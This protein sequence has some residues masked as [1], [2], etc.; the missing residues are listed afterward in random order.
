MFEIIIDYMM[1]YMKKTVWMVVAMAA[2]VLMGSCGHQAGR[3]S[4][5]R[6]VYHWKTTYNPSEWEKDWM[7]QHKVD[8]LYV[9]LFDVEAGD[10]VGDPD[11]RMVPTATT[12]F[13]QP[14]PD[15]IEVVPV[16][17]ITLD[18]IRALDVDEW[19]YGDK[20]LY[21]KLI[22]KRIK[23]MMAE[24]Y[25]GQVH[26]VQLDCDWTQ[27]TERLYFALVRE[28]KKL[29]HEDDILLS[30]TLRLHQLHEVEHPLK[31]DW[32]S[33]DSL[34]F[35][36][37]LLMCYNTG[38]L[39]DHATRN[40]ILDFGDVKPY[41]KQYGLD[42]LPRTDVALPTYGWGVEFTRD[43]QFIRIV[44]SHQLPEAQRSRWDRRVKI[45]EEW[46]ETQEIN[47]TKQALSAL[48]DSHTT[49]LYHLDSLNLSKYSYEDIEAFYRR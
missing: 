42:S 6:G 4:K 24:H 16:V 1:N 44:H 2:L 22:V 36:R 27:Q 23:V 20:Q 32:G 31:N 13:Q 26:E 43:N 37:S 17:Y 5:H 41:L 45:R 15:N 49:I 30:G 9:R 19:F 34:P 14:L 33:V 3:S 7:K 12:V 28:V 48:D 47:K 8:R 11:W 25:K 29:L 38:R 10:Q 46:G 39:Q 18:A 21:A 40:S 35:D